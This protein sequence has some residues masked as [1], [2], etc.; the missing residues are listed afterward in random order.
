MC[1]FYFIEFRVDFLLLVP[2]KGTKE[3]LEF[4]FTFDTLFS[5]VVETEGWIFYYYYMTTD[6][7]DDHFC[8]N[9]V[10]ILWALGWWRGW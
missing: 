8:S 2:I 1:N 10:E 7:D 5:A 3:K 9:I 4:L 6:D